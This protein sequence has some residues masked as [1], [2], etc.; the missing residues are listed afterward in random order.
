[1]SH[2]RLP[3]LDSAQTQQNKVRCHKMDAFCVVVIAVA[4][5]VVTVVVVTVVATIIAAVV[6]VAAAT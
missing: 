5:V 2:C 3:E 4:V 6:I 1:M